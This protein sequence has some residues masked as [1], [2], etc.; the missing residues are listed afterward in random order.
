MLMLPRINYRLITKGKLREEYSF[1]WIICT[2]V[3]LLF[4]IWRNGLDVIANKS[5]TTVH[6]IQMK[7]YSSRNLPLVIN[8]KIKNIKINADTTALI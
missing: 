1:I 7:E 5:S 6:I 4:A 8:L 2:V 3:L